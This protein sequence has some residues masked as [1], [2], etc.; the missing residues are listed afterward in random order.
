MERL[1]RRHR[2]QGAWTVRRVAIPETAIAAAVVAHFRSIPGVTVYQEVSLGERA[3][4]VVKQGHVLHV[5]ECKARFGLDVLR[6]ASNWKRFAHRASVATP[7][8]RRDYKGSFDAGLCE[9]LGVGWFSVSQLDAWPDSEREWRVHEVVRS[10]FR[11]RIDTKLGDVLMPEHETFTP[12]GS[13]AGTYWSPWRATCKALAEYVHANPGCTM[14]AAIAGIEHHY[15]R[16][17]TARSSLAHWVHVGKV[18][19]VERR[20]GQ[21]GLWPAEVNP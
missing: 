15:R 21:R 19:G 18:P 1:P 3:D 4:L 11:R 10:P 2:G 6:Q 5:I 13:N 17:T 14:K 12:A 20:E 7:P 16:D 9:A 8:N